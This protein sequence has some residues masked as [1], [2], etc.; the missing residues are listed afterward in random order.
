MTIEP[1]LV[2]ISHSFI[3]PVASHKEGGVVV[4]I[5]HGYVADVKAWF[6]ATF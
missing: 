3:G 6:S 2:E 4:G 1:S 5:A